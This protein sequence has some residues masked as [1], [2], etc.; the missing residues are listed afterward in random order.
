MTALT[1]SRILLFIPAY[2]C[3][4]QIGRVVA[5]LTAEAAERIDAVAVIDNQSPDGTR[6]RAIETLTATS[7]IPWRV[8]RNDENYGLGGSHKVAIDLAL[9]E[10]FTHLV[11][12]HGDDQAS[13][14]DV[15]PLL[16]PQ[17]LDGLDAL[18]GARFARG[19]RLEG[20]SRVRTAGNHVYNWLF[21]AVGRRRFQDLGSGLNVFRVGAFAEQPHRQFSDDL[22][23]NYFLCLLM[24]RQRWNIRF[25][26]ITWREEDQRSNVKLV[27]QGLRTLRFL[28]TYARNPDAFLAADHRSQTHTYTAQ[29]VASGDGRARD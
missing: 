26:P 20:Y 12:L 9:A 8:L 11:V 13:L 7:P 6:E 3:E 4:G 25:F 23:F 10:G 16:T 15:L 24:A 29:V 21:S 1:S 27:D 19:A 14:S 5:Q 2:R 22:T 18:L 17:T 28:G